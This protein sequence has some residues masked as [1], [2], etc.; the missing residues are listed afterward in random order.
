M[1]EAGEHEDGDAKAENEHV[2]RRPGMVLA[3]AVD[4]P[5]DEA[6][7]LDVLRRQGASDLETAE[8]HVE[9]G[10]WVDFDPLSSPHLVH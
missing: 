8:G 3:V 1:K 4:K 7:A 9:H 2:V 10:D 5:A 6:R